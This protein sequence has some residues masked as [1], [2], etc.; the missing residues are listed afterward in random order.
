[1]SPATYRVVFDRDESGA[2][3]VSVP[4]VRGCH[5]HGRSLNQART[6]IREA[7][8]L[9]VDDAQNTEL[10]EEIRL[11]ARALRAVEQSRRARQNADSERDKA[12]AATV[13]AARTLVEELDLGLRDAADLLG[14]SHQRVQQIVKGYR[15]TPSSSATIVTF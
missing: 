11:P 15:L 8:A 12:T 9:W 2:W 6:R 10:E 3:I 14:L 1:M 7:L 4:S 5:S 13:A